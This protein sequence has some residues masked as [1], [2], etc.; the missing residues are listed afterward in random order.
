MM[1]LTC[2]HSQLGALQNATRCRLLQPIQAKSEAAK[3]GRP[4]SHRR[5]EAGT[6]SEARERS[7]STLGERGRPRPGSRGLVENLLDRECPAFHQAG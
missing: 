5:A 6:A 1:P 3:R 4:K 7:T 2:N